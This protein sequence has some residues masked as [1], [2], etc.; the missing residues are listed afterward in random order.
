MMK[1][2]HLV[3]VHAHLCVE[4]VSIICRFFTDFSYIE[5]ELKLDT[6][7]KLFAA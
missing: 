1:Q 5:H 3:C 4:R 6:F 7:K 2:T